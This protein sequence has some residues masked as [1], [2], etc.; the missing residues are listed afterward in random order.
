MVLFVGCRDLEPPRSFHADLG[1]EGA[2]L[3]PT[4]GAWHDSAVKEG[5]AEWHPFPS[6]QAA[7][8]ESAKGSLGEAGSGS[9]NPAEASVRKFIQEFNE[10]VAEK[11]YESMPDYFVE[12][13]RGQVKE[14]LSFQKTALEKVQALVQA[15]EEKAPGKGDAIKKLF[16]QVLSSQSFGEMKVESLSVVS[17]TEVLGKVASPPVGTPVPE[18]ALEVRF[19]SVKDEWEMESGAMELA[20]GM[21]PLLQMAMGQ[22]DSMVE[23][24]RSGAVPVDA[25]VSQLEAALTMAQQMG[26]QEAGG[27]GDKSNDAA[28]SGAKDEGRK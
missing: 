6:L 15:I 28:Q 19:V 11:D 25:L 9:G 12:G 26:G 13:Q 24:I 23:G 8:K 2:A 21:M 3:L 1:D 4:P 18:K 10:V 14:L 17:E 7:G 20:A 5:Q 16:E 27:S 22:F